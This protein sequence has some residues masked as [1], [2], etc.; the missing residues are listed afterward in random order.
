MSSLEFRKLRV[1]FSARSQNERK[2]NE[3]LHFLEETFND[4]STQAINSK[5]NRRAKKID[6]YFPKSFQSKGKSPKTLEI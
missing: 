6:E 5:T 4:P 1:F 2:I 3:L